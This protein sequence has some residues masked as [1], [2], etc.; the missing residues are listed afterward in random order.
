MNKAIFTACICIALNSICIGAAFAAG[1]QFTPFYL[2]A[3]TSQTSA[4]GCEHSNVGEHKLFCA[5]NKSSCYDKIGLSGRTSL[6]IA[7]FNMINAC[8]LGT[9]AMIQIVKEK[10][11]ICAFFACIY[12]L[13]I[14]I[15][16]ANGNEIL[17]TI[18]TRSFLYRILQYIALSLYQM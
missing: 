15:R 8:E 17:E 1:T 12:M 10:L 16:S 14:D 11:S 13:C 2:P 3:Q 18:L 6:L 9:N 4:I 5:K 7:K